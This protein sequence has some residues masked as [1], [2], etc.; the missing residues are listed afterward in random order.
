MV[1]ANCE[2]QRKWHALLLFLMQFPLSIMGFLGQT[3]SGS[4]LIIFLF[5]LGLC[6]TVI[7]DWVPS[8]E[9]YIC[10]RRCPLG[11]VLDRLR[12]WHEDLQ[13][14]QSCFCQSRCYSCRIP[15]GASAAGMPCSRV[16]VRRAW[17]Q[18]KLYLYFSHQCFPVCPRIWSFLSQ[19]NSCWR[20]MNYL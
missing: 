12:D 5:F 18:S 13:V 15:A 1:S 6:L 16:C 7:H 20:V 11:R 9:T 8:L 10:W 2:M 14:R 17:W 19:F 4:R 3:H